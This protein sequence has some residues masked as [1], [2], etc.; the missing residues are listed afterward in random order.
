MTYEETQ[1]WA[2]AVEC[3]TS[4]GFDSDWHHQLRHVSSEIRIDLMGAM[5]GRLGLDRGQYDKLGALA[6]AWGEMKRLGLVTAELGITDDEW[7]RGIGVA[8]R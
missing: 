6:T 4:D 1:A 5:L 8:A 3:F 2:D 7:L